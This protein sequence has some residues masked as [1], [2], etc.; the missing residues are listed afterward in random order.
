MLHLLVIV[1]PQYNLTIMFWQNPAQ[2]DHRESK[3]EK[4]CCFWP[5]RFAEQVP[6]ATDMFRSMEGLE[7]SF[8]SFS[9]NDIASSYN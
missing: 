2:L 5:L 1:E 6:K 8:D 7:S 3:H 9:P 4:S